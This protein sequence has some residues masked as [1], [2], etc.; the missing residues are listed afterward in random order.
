MFSRE[1]AVFGCRAAGWCGPGRGRLRLSPPGP[2]PRGQGKGGSAR[3]PAGSP[4]AA[5]GHPPSFL[6]APH[7]EGAQ[8]LA[9]VLHPWIC[10]PTA[11]PEHG[12]LNFLTLTACWRSPLA[13]R[14]PR[15]K[16]PW[17]SAGERAALGPAGN[18]GADAGAALLRSV[19]SAPRGTGCL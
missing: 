13:L 2:P 15:L 18:G 16:G 7:C 5:S 6:L 10:A 8:K 19:T 11:R 17:P 12:N 14:L 3:G 9:L 1:G 4:G